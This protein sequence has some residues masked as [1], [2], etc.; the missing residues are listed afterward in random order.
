[1]HVRAEYLAQRRVQQVGRGVIE[2]R[3]AAQ[4]RINLRGHCITDLDLALCNLAD[5]G[6]RVAQFLRIADVEARGSG[7]Q[8]ALIAHLSASLG[9]ERSAIEDDL[10][11]LAGPQPLDLG[12]LL[13]Q[14]EH[15]R[16]V[17]KAVIA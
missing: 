11:L 6:V 16:L 4:L 13:D 2:N 8:D 17:R 5:M 1:M 12:A 7:R 15:A 14:L 9:I 10:P 3:R